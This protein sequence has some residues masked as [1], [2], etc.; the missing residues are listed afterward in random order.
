M[1]RQGQPV[2]ALQRAVG[3]GDEEAHARHV[4]DGGG[5]V[6]AEGEA[7]P[8]RE[9]KSADAAHLDLDAGGRAG[10]GPLQQLARAA[11]VELNMH[12]Q[13]PAGP[14][15][16][17][18]HVHMSNSLNTPIEA[19]EHAYPFR[20]RRYE[21]RRDSGGRGRHRGGDGVRRDLQILA[22]AEVSLLTERRL[23][24]PHGLAGGED[25]EKGRNVLIRGGVEAELP[26][27]GT[28][29]GRLTHCA[30]DSSESPMI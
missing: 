16:S 2:R 17:A 13:G 23:Q 24:G 10:D 20:I 12:A 30:D 7:A 27:K 5:V 21:I 3:R 18:V 25:G 14:G 28:F 6:D 8:R 15:L 22:D 26:G 4:A 11:A 1:Q 9:Q 29:D 19:L